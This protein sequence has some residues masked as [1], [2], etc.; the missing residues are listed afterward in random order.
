LTSEFGR[1]ATL[2]TGPTLSPGIKGE[3]RGLPRKKT[4]PD[5]EVANLARRKISAAT[6]PGTPS[7]PARGEG[8]KHSLSRKGRER[9]SPLKEGNHRG[10]M[11]DR[12]RAWECSLIREGRP[13]QTR[14]GEVSEGKGEK[15]NFE[16]RDDLLFKIK[17][18]KGPG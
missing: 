1:V 2:F 13:Y 12:S 18:K 15:S 11:W 3:K 9:V 16:I 7:P 10:A 4:I 8:R 14:R 6:R 5:T 17:K